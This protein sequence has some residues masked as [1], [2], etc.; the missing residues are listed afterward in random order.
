MLEREVVGTV[1]V[2][3]QVLLIAELAVWTGS[4]LDG[5][6]VG[7]VEDAGGVRV[8]ALPALDYRYSAWA[9]R[10]E[11]RLTGGDRVIVVGTRD[12]LARLLAAANSTTAD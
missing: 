11:K 10:P 2:K 1:S 9:P 3:R 8:I 5:A 12:G 4:P 6:T 7:M